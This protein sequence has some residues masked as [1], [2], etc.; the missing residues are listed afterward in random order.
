LTADYLPAKQ[1]VRILVTSGASCPDA[2]VEAVIRKL[3]IFYGVESKIER[4]IAD[5][6]IEEF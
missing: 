4:I 2:V 1:P 6:G 3:A 5:F